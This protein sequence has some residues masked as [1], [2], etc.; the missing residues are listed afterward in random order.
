[1]VGT[2]LTVIVKVAG[3]PLQTML[4]MVAAGVTVIVPVKGDVPAFVAIKD[5]M[6]AVPLAANPIDVL[7]FVQLNTV[8]ATAL[9]KAIAVVEELLHTI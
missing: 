7:S 4:P 8:P 1:M 2:G 5:E 3:T 9:E 6:S